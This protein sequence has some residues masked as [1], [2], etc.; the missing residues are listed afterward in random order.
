MAKSGFDILFSALGINPL[1]MQAAL[2]TTIK[3]INELHSFMKT[4][5]M[6][7]TRIEKKLGIVDAEIVSI[8]DKHGAANG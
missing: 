1:E 7:L 6:R 8:E 2:G 5:D 4:V 3:N